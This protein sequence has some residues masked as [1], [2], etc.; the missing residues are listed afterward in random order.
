MMGPSPSPRY[1]FQRPDDRGGVDPLAVYRSLG[2]GSHPQVQEP[3]FHV[4]RTIP[5]YG[6]LEPLLENGGDPPGAAA[7]LNSNGFADVDKALA[8]LAYETVRRDIRPSAPSR[9]DSVFCFFDPLEAFL[10]GD[11]VA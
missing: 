8:E 4:R 11:V 10:F 9:L 1:K 5:A 7:H 2:V 3:H 6:A